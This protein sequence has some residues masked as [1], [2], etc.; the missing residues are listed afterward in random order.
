M[1]TNMTVKEKGIDDQKKATELKELSDLPKIDVS[2]NCFPP[3]DNFGGTN[4][5][6]FAAGVETF[7]EKFVFMKRNLFNLPSENAAKLFIRE[8]TFWLKYFNSSN[9]KYNSMAMKI[10]LVL[11]D[12][13]YR[14]PS[15]P[16]NA[17]ITL[18][19]FLGA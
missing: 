4:L 10:F 11:P 6:Q 19:H 3:A 13:C 18:K 12:Y 2:S 9:S 1:M 5:N 7:Y 16:P 17:K 14:N 8:L 15:R